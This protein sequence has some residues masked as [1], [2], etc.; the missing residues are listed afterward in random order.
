MSDTPD[1]L[2]LCTNPLLKQFD[3][4]L[5]KR[6]NQQ[7]DV[8]CWSYIQTADEPCSIEVAIDLLHNYLKQQSQPVHLIGH[9]LS[10]IVG[11]LYARQYPEQV[12]S[13]TLLSVGA[14]PAAGWH[15]HYYALR[16][17]LPCNRATVLNQMVR[18]LFGPQSPAKAAGIAKLLAQVLD[19]ELAP[20]SLGHRDTV[21]QGR[22]EPPLLVCHGSQD[23][24]MDANAKILWK[25]WLKPGDRLWECPEGRHFFHYEYPDRSSRPILEFWQPS[26]YQSGLSLVELTL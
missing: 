24:I 9:S 25:Q 6:L 23:V 12:K 7:A 5:F 21:S 13:L 19:T 14:K 10:G 3:Q 8:R 17:L 16:Q 11:L 26:T 15:A 20:H 4:R 22:I 1:G 18:L 2:W